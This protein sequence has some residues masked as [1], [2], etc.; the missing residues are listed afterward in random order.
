MSTRCAIVN[1]SMA[2]Y[3]MKKCKRFTLR[4]QSECSGIQKRYKTTRQTKIYQATENRRAFWMTLYISRDSRLPGLPEQRPVGRGILA[5]DH[6]HTFLTTQGY[7]RPPQMSD[8]LIAVATFEATRTLKTIHTTHSHVHSNKVDMI[9]MI[10]MGKWYSGFGG[11]KASWYLS[12]RWGKTPKKNLPRKL[13]PIGDRTRAR[14]V[15]GAHAIFRWFCNLYE[16][17]YIIFITILY[18]TPIS[19]SQNFEL[20]KNI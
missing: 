20:T 4:Q 16:T 17:I 9:R 13:V 12:Y 5:M 19:S 1:Y 8:Q 10:M 11:P 15:T 18:L 14:C 6:I 7:V 2:R 3:R